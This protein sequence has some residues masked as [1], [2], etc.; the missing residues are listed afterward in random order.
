[1]AE[2]S[3]DPAKSVDATVVLRRP[4]RAVGAN[5]SREEIAQALSA[6][7]ADLDTVRRFA[8]AHGLHVDRESAAERSI[9]VSGT[10][11]QMQEAFGDGSTL[12]SELES[13]AVAVLG[14]DKR[15]IAKPR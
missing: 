11:Q 2:D 3:S 9:R 6:D 7:P 14:R 5:A 10:E 1:M 8:A 13:V 12:P 15:P 4:E